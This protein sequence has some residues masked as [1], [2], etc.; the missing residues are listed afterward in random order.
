MCCWI[1]VSISYLLFLISCHMK[2]SK[3]LRSSLNVKFIIGKLWDDVTIQKWRPLDV[4]HTFPQVFNALVTMGTTF[5]WGNNCAMFRSEFHFVP[6]TKQR[7]STNPTDVICHRDA[8]FSRT[9]M[10]TLKNCL[11]KFRLLT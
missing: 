6:I 2:H 4:R 8:L 7:F 3:A 11:N 10:L 5:N 9:A 1:S